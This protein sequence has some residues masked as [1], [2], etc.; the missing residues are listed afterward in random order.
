MLSEIAASSNGTLLIGFVVVVERE[1]GSC[2][3]SYLCTDLSGVPVEYR[4]TSPIKPTRA[5]KLL[6]GA[7]LERELFG[8]CIAGVLLKNVEHKPAAVLTDRELVFRGSDGYDFPVFQV[9]FGAPGHG[10]SETTRSVETPAGTIGLRWRDKDAPRANEL[11][12]RLCGVEL[13]EPFARAQNILEEV[14]RMAP[15]TNSESSCR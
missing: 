1:D 11:V 2:E 14:R 15:K 12:E 5:Q 6:Y 4:Y 9:T 3:G 13:K 8:R 7:A 10:D